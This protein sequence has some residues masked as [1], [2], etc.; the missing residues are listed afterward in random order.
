MCDGI[1]VRKKM[2]P[3]VMSSNERCVRREG[4]EESVSVGRDIS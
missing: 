4:K 2:L 3:A 1:L